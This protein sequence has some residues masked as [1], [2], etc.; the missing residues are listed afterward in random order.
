MPNDF[1]IKDLQLPKGWCD[2]VKNAVIH[3]IALAHYAITYARGWAVNSPLQRVR[4]AAQL[5]QAQNEIVLLREE[6]R[7]KD[8]R[9]MRIP[10]HERPHYASMER[11][12]ILELKAARNLSTAQTARMFLVSEATIASWMKRLDEDGPDAL[13]RVPCVVNKFPQFVKYLVCRLKMLCPTMGK[14]R[15][16]QV[17]ARAGL[18][19]GKTTIQR[20]I[21][22]KHTEPGEGRAIVITDE[23][24]T[25][26]VTAK[27]PN[28]VWHV[29]LT[30]V[31]V[32]VGFWVPW[33]PLALQ[34]YW[35]FCWWLAVVID[36][37]SRR[38]MGFAVFRKQPTSINIRA[39][40]GRLMARSKTKPKYIICD[41]GGQ[42]WNPGFKQW[43]KRKNIRPR[44]G[45]VGQHG[46]IAI[47]ERFIRSMKYEY[48]RHILVPMHI[49][50]MRQEIV[51]YID[52]YNRHRPHQGLEGATPLEIYESSI[53]ANRKARYEP[54]KHW[55]VGSGCA[56]PY[57]E[58]RPEQGK[59]LRFV[60]TFAD[61]YRRLP[62]A[63][64]RE[65]A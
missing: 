61:K 58:P 57:A 30:T 26:V 2:G 65:V 25:R 19:L 23:K 62:I 16:A 44:F 42:F 13:V 24:P 38:A 22:E 14:V 64:L 5:E 48:L 6:V 46:S 53:P 39:F 37:Y 49:T 29:D 36:H 17:L 20:Y 59:H 4:L 33:L 56:A 63:Q 27:Y 47:I 41:K 12:A 55:P 35:P 21:K 7:I 34:Q 43:C 15:I 31:P 9:M 54:R 8:A 40:L 45:A 60:L 28:H 51:C 10:A 32:A 50:H 3:T 18:H 11:M 52:W 1:P